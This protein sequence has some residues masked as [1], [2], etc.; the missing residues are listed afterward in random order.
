MPSQNGVKRSAKEPKQARSKQTR[1]KILEATLELLDQ[2]GIEGVSTNSI[3]RRAK[4]NIASLYQYFPD[5]IAIL[6]VLAMNFSNKQSFLICNYLDRASIDASIA[7]VCEGIVD[8]LID[9]TRGD[10]ALLHLQSALIVM[11]DLLEAYRMTNVEIGQ[12]MRRFIRAWGIEM[13]NEEITTTMFCVGEIFSGLQNLALSRDPNYDP[14]VI[15]HL[16]VLLTAYYTYLSQ[17]GESPCVSA[18]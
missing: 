9:G 18:G 2:D 16:K 14:K 12:S 1:Q 15:E 6:R 7:E 3:A 8:A 10:R 17:K 4:V 5:K 11:P 13:D